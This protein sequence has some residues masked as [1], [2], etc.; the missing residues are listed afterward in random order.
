MP[1]REAVAYWKYNPLLQKPTSLKPVMPYGYYW[2]FGPDPAAGVS[3]GQYHDKQ[4]DISVVTENAAIV[5]SPAT[6]V[7]MDKVDDVPFEEIKAQLSEA[8]ASRGL[9]AA[10]CVAC[11]KDM[12]SDYDLSEPDK[13]FCVGCGGEV[14]VG[15]GNNPKEKT[16]GAAEKMSEIKARIRAK[17]KA[18]AKEQAEAKVKEEKRKALA[19]RLKKRKEERAKKEAEAAE[20]EASKTKFIPLET[21]LATMKQIKAEEEGDEI[22]IEEIMEAM[23]DELEGD[24][25]A[26]MDY[27]EEEAPAEEPASDEAEMDYSEE[28]APADESGDEGDDESY[29]ELDM[30]LGMLKKKKRLE[31][32]KAAE[33]KKATAEGEEEEEAPA[34]EAPPADNAEAEDD[35]SGD[36]GANPADEPDAEPD[37]EPTSAGDEPPAEEADTPPNDEDSQPEPD[38]LS[39]E[40]PLP[41]GGDSEAMRFEPL[42][43]FENVTRDQISMELFDEEGE[44][45]FWNITVAGV[46]AARV[47]LCKQHQPDTIR[48]IF[49]SEGYASDIADHCEKTG[50]VKTMNRV[51]AEFWAN[52]TSD[53][54]IAAKFQKE[55]Q[56]S[57][58]KERETMV[59]SFRDDFLNCINIVT[60]GLNKNFYP[61]MGH[62]IKAALLSN[63]AS[64]HPESA[65]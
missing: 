61:D 10:N 40:N 56:A 59:A 57:F 30:I 26:S 23:D 41:T 60:C 27:E 11:Q 36:D 8:T 6:G 31:A 19:E 16:M 51:N 64:P 63:L 39:E 62:D 35:S 53:S 52:Q 38:M 14:Q 43:S 7:P 12:V 47:Q 58:N 50:F 42:A 33:A 20:A 18:K 4:N 25:E 22:P 34:E 2:Y 32:K 49:C 46:P 1:N 24:D 21:I 9:S 17:A 37:R 5:Y 29:M 48:D 55:A 54:K 45:P 44:N 13:V 65:L 15:R 3:Y 28:E